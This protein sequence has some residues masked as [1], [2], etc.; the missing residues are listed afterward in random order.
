MY[1]IYTICFWPNVH[2]KE[3]KVPSLLEDME[4]DTKE[5]DPVP[6]FQSN[7]IQPQIKKV[8]LFMTHIPTSTNPDS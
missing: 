5:K 2:I 7:Q 6:L 1:G 8:G 3:E 4:D